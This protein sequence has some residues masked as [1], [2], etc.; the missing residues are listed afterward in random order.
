MKKICLLLVLILVMSLY[1]SPAMAAGR[2]NVEQ[3]NYYTIK[4]GSYYYGYAY[5]KVVN[6]GNKP[7]KVNTGLLEIFDAEGDAITSTDNYSAF[8]RY[9]NPGEYTYFRMY[10]SIKEI[11]SPDE[12]DDYMLT[13]SG[14][15]EIDKTMVRLPCE[16]DYQENVQRGY[17]KYNYM[18][19]TITNDTEAPVYQPR[20]VFA[21]LDEDENIL[22]LVEDYLDSNEALLPGSSV[23]F[24][25]AV[26]SDFV[27]YM[28]ENNLVPAS[29]DVIGYCYL[30]E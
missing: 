9:L 17:Y 29:L 24:R 13:I 21:L 7:I 3:E 19:A 15:S 11:N 1:L 25:V 27:S 18:Y 28:E 8:A 22:Y 16:C 20:V 5:A 12:V 4:D 2:L 26:D 10:T 23:L 14:R 30:E 6:A